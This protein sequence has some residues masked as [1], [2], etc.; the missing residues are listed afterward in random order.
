MKKIVL[1]IGILFTTLLNAQESYN[2][3]SVDLGLGANKTLRNAGLATRVGFPHAS[4][5]VRYMTNPFFGVRFQVDYDKF[6]SGKNAVAA[7]EYN[8][9]DLAFT[10]EGVANIGRLLHFEDWT[11]RIGLLAHA[12]PGGTILFSKTPAKSRD[13]ALHL[14]MGITGL[15]RINDRFALTGDLS[16][17]MNMLQG[18]AL[19]MRTPLVSTGFDGVFLTASV[20]AT[21][22]LGKNQKHADWIPNDGGLGD[23]V[24]ALKSRMDKVEKDMN[25]DDNDGV[26]NY[27]DKENDTPEGTKVDQHGVAI[28]ADIDTDGDGV[29]DSKDLCPTMKGSK[30]ANGCPDADGDGVADFLD[31]CP[32]EAGTA[33][34]QGCKESRKTNNSMTGDASILP[35]DLRTLQF[36]LG[37]SNIKSKYNSSLNSLAKVMKANPNYKLIISGH[38]D[39][40]GDDA[41][42]TSLSQERAENVKAYL[43]KK[44]IDGSRLQTQG[45]GSTK[46]IASNDNEAGRS[47][48][49]RVE[50]GVQK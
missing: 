36:E 32:N 48:N 46:P 34:N 12:G 30:S 27:L 25:D 9:N 47:K 20:G 38:A 29:V 33:E 10:G 44:G 6:K 23:E 2:K 35:A 18:R 8:A 40:T 13:L 37:K 22:Y 45:F 31:L 24:T 39:I 50:F 7:K 5:G 21:I 4:L 15:L 43:V 26:A 28:P 42:N 1:A 49:R 3:F 11:N 19:D 41:I 14:N 17:R 16:S